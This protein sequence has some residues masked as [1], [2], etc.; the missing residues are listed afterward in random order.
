MAGFIFSIS[1]NE[2][3]DGV[4]KYVKNGYF[5]ALV[6]K[7]L[8]TSK[9]KQ[10]AAGVLA[11]Y[12][13][14]RQGDNVYFLSNRK[15]YG[16]GK[17]VLLGSDCKYKNYLE[18]TSL[19]TKENIEKEDYALVGNNPCARW[20]C[21]FK[22]DNV[23]FTK[24]VDMDDVLLYKPTAFKMLRAFQDRSFI[25]IDD[26]ENRA[27]KE[28]IY[29]KNRD[30]LKSGI[31]YDS[32]EH[33][34]IEKYDLNKYKLLPVQALVKYH[35]RDNGEADIEMLLEAALVDKLIKN[36]TGE[37]K[38]D[39]VSHQVIASPFK[40]IA[41]IDKID[42][43]AYRFLDAFPQEE[44]PIEKYMIIELKK[45]KGN[46]ETLLQAMRY[47]DWV[48]N[49]YASGDYSLIKARVVALDY[50]KKIR[51]DK[52]E[53]CVR[54]FI[55]STHP[56]IT[57]KWTDLQLFTYNVDNFGEVNFNEYDGFDAKEILC[58]RLDILGLKYNKIGI[59]VGGNNYTPII[60]IPLKHIAFFNNYRDCD[61]EILQNDGWEIYELDKLKE[62]NDIDD[63][64]T[65]IVGIE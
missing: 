54:N 60:K 52:N 38:W 61:K 27:L 31:K 41:Y 17:L 34:R 42:I 21:F 6:P 64:M 50:T 18:A 59:T 39:Y 8:D 51:K 5:S 1:S 12:L 47:V 55:S 56:I 22:P 9:A 35:N 44:K 37:E 62:E 10:V 29:L 7:E 32:S 11:D 13:S 23:F 25:K 49:E 19:M 48:C 53:S 24:G 28:Y 26:E 14:M 36:S 20:I 57:E 15:L 16:V 2:G 45:G 46:K 33:K 65:K 63:L 30:D 40:P 43:F 4:K 3:V 58:E